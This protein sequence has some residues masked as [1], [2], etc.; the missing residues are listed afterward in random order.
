MSKMKEA[1]SLKIHVNGS[2]RLLAACDKDLLEMTFKDGELRLAT[3]KDF[4][5]DE[6]VD[7]DTFLR[8]MKTVNMANLVGKRTVDAAIEAGFID[9]D[10]VITISGIPHAQMLKL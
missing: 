2:H 4:Y 3:K 1:I 6:F 8:L 9:K 5:F 7:D 10:C